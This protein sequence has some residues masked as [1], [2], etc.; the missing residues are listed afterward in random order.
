MLK[1]LH[2]AAPLALAAFMLTIQNVALAVLPGSHPNPV[3]SR[4]AP[5]VALSERIANRA[6]QQATSMCSVGYCYRGVKRAL[7][8]IGIQLSGTAAW[9]AK[10]QL[11]SDGRF[12][13]VPMQSLRKGDI[14]VHDRSRAHPYGHIAV[15]LG[16]GQEA[17]DHVQKLVLGGRYGRTVV[18][19]ARH[20][21][22]TDMASR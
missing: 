16:D 4:P 14:L 19:R 21:A 10:D 13:M 11:Q 8:A 9:M 17:S 3:F 2:L 12:V 18:F 6:R 1:R 15:Y 7:N 20:N 22:L 5:A